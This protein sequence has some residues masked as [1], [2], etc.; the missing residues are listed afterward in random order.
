MTGNLEQKIIS[1]AGASASAVAKFAEK[2]VIYIVKA[3]PAPFTVEST[4]A[5]YRRF[6][7]DS[8]EELSN[9]EGDKLVGRI[10]SSLVPK[11]AGYSIGIGLNIVAAS[12]ALQRGYGEWYAAALAL[13]NA[14]DVLRNHSRLGRAIGASTRRGK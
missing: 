8:G 9:F 13:A 7:T 5:G 12:Y 1:G 14:G 6:I 4:V 11:M 3:L 10:F 2:A